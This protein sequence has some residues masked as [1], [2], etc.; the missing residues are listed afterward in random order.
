MLDAQLAQLR[1]EGC[2]KIYRETTSGAQPSRRELL[3]LL[4]RSASATW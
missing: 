2:A 1:T 3:R 4:K